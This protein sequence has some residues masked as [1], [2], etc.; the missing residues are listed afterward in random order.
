MD[1]RN[2]TDVVETG[3]S[4][5]AFGWGLFAFVSRVVGWEMC[6]RRVGRETDSSTRRS[7]RFL[8]SHLFC[9]VVSPRSSQM[10]AR[11]PG[12]VGSVPLGIDQRGFGC[13]L[14]LPHVVFCFV[15]LE[16]LDIVL[17]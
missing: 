2:E 11:G 13:L 8:P 14:A 1:G 4:S 6:K 5:F 9:F 7:L 15:S 3:C 12:G 16:E 17:L 10:H